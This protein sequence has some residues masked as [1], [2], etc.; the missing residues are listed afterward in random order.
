MS[1]EIR[2]QR[3]ELAKRIERHTGR[4]GVH[5]TAIPSLYFFR[6]SNLTKPAHRV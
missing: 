4:D 5:K 1:E 2:D 3:D 6:N